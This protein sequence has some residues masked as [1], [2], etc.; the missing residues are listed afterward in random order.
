MRRPQKRTMLA[1]LDRRR[2]CSTGGRVISTGGMLLAGGVVIA[3]WDGRG[4]EV[5]EGLHPWTARRLQELRRL[6]EQRGLA[7]RKFSDE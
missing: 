4:L 2:D 5:L 6:M 7:M 1:F 3:R